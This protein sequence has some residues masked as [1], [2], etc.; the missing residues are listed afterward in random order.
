MLDI[1]DTAGQEVSHILTFNPLLP[2]SPFLVS[3]S[4]SLSPSQPNHHHLTL[5][6]FTHHS[7]HFAPSSHPHPSHP[8]T[9]TLITPSPSSHPHTLTQEFSAMREQYMHT[10]E[11]FLLVYSIIDRNSFEEIPKFYRQILRVKDR[12]C[13]CVCVCV[14]VCTYV[15]CK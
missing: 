7:S 15:H 6:P 8:H 9:L 5:S 3:L 14:C 11:G 12:Y 4:F 1:L 10:G 2:P 13:V